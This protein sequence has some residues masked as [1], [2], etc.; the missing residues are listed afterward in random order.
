MGPPLSFGMSDS[1]LESACEPSPTGLAPWVYWTSELYCYGKCLRALAKYPRALPLFAYA[2][3]GVAL[4]SNL[5]PHEIRN[6]ARV[7][8]TSHPVKAERYRSSADKQVVRICHPW[9]Y[10]R[11]SLQIER[12]PSSKGTLVFVVHHAPGVKWE[13]P[14]TQEYFQTLRALPAKYQPVVLCLHMHDIV[15]GL[16]KELRPLGFPIVTAG[17]TSS[18]HF[19]DR[20][21][22]LVRN[23]SYATSQVW[24]SQVAYCVEL[25][26]PYFFLGER[27]KLINLSTEEF[28]L[29]E[30]DFQDGYHKRFDREARGLFAD[31]VDEV[32]LEQKR[33]VETLLGVDSVTS[34]PQV[35]WL[36][37]REFF[38]HRR[39]WWPLWLRPIWQSWRRHGPWGFVTRVRHRLRSIK[40]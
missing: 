7:H 17:N 23:F 6:K 2:D 4:H 34:R 36:L 5:F 28:P 40:P 33:F 15:S 31:P 3:H 13:N 25:G 38:R 29:G 10:Y 1:E 14:N 35:S 11:R 20:F 24:G 30:V 21:Y 26:I 22:E 39:A 9:V 19:V 12:A 27:P 16:H 32:T 37:W 8:F 18:V